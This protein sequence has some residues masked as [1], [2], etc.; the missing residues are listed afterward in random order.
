MNSEKGILV[1]GATGPAGICL[2]RELLHRGHHAIAYV[3]NPGKIPLELASSPKLEV[4]PGELTESKKLASA[5]S[6]CTAVISFLGSSGSKV[7][8]VKLFASYYSDYIFP[9]MRA[10]SVQRIYAMGT[11]SI[12]R[13]EDQPSALRWLAIAIF[14][15][16]YPKMLATMLEIEKVFDTKADNLEWLLFRIASIPGKSDE[17]SWRKDRE[18]GDTFVGWVAES[19]W[20]FSQKRAALARWLVDAVEGKAD[21]WIGKMP[22]VSKLAG[23][24]ANLE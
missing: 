4:I 18:D 24:K 9:T 6:K 23:S 11:I 22:A 21:T 12:R 5:I 3:R 15:R 1:L 17:T 7:D 13:P 14:G 10:Y 20:S 16:V 2:L 8:D 19:G